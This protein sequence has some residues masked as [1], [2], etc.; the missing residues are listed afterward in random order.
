MEYLQ[1]IY[2]IAKRVIIHLRINGF[3]R[4]MEADLQSRFVIEPNHSMSLRDN[5]I[6]FLS[7][8]CVSCIIAGG[9]AWHGMWLIAPISAVEM[10]CLMIALYLCW[11]RSNCK[12]VIEITCDRVTV[13]SGMT[14]PEKSCVLKRAWAHIV[15]LRKQ[16][17][18]QTD[19]LLIRAPGTQVEVGSCLNAEE[20]RLLAAQ[21]RQS[22]NAGW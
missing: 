14:G 10:I 22:L 2:K 19:R 7:L 1:R 17:N 8:L 18:H 9:F 12:E 6:L 11:R 16:Q 13:T 4:M 5:W 20:K 3:S 15:F 21:L